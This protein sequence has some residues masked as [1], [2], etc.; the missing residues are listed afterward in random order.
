[1][2]SLRLFVADG[3]PHRCKL[4]VLLLPISGA[5]VFC[6]LVPSTFRAEEDLNGGGELV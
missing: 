1:M 4:E 5:L 6:N 3:L 2:I